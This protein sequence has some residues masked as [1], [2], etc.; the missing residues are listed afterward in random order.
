MKAYYG[1]DKAL[2][3]KVASQRLELV[4]T[5]KKLIGNHPEIATVEFS[6]NMTSMASL[7]ADISRVVIDGPA[8]GTSEARQ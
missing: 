4:E 7:V 8:S 5:H 3:D 1:A 2:A 6:T